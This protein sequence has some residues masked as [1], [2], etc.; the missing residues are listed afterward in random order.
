MAARFWVGGTGTWDTTTTTHWSATSGGAGGASVPTT[1]D[2]VTFDASSGSGTCTTATGATCSTLT[3]SSSVFLT[4]GAAFTANSAVTLTIG[5]V[6]LATFTFTCTTFNSNNANSR[7]LAFGTGNITCISSGTVFN[8]ATTTNLTLT[9]TP[10]VN[11]T[12]AGSVAV[13]VSTG[14]TVGISDQIS[15][16]I[17]AGTYTFSNGANSFFKNLNF[18]GFSGSIANGLRSIYGNLTIPAT[19]TITSGTSPTTF[20]GT[21]GTQIINTNTVTWDTP[22]T[23]NGVGGTFQL[24]SALTMGA[25]NG[26]ISLT[27]GTIDLNGFTLLCIS[28]LTLAGT[29]SILFNGGTLNCTASATN[30]F[31]NLSSSAGFTTVAGVGT[32]TIT[33]TG[34]AAKTFQG[35]GST[36]N[37]TLNQGGAGV[38]TITG[39]NTF[40]NITNTVTPC[41]VTFPASVINNFSNFNLNGTAGNL[42]TLNSSTSGTQ[43]TIHYTG[44]GAIVCDYLSIQDSNAT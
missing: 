44:T 40:T 14:V 28:F 35:G 3:I 42:V 41:T 38:L 20:A 24:G 23:F 15:V 37:C 17:T 16:N 34:A 22:I 1:A 27:N 29:K 11:L 8:I 36:F 32:G 39:A 21:S 25:T 5:V 9:G 10:I 13:S 31:N 33:M 30:A 6:N 12:Y 18:T 26:T 4:L 19:T 43:A 7:T 2:I